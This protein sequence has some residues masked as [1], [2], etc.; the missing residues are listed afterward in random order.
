M[1][2]TKG[3]GQ[4]KLE[5]VGEGEEVHERVRNSLKWFKELVSCKIV[6]CR[7]CLGQLSSTD[8]SVL[9][10]DLTSARSASD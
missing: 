5:H 2:Q 10:G 8:A 4:C 3:L 6:H 7:L 9:Y 1:V